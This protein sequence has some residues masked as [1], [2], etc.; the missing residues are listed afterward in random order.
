M[1][2]SKVIWTGLILCLFPC[3]VHSQGKFVQKFQYLAQTQIEDRR[4]PFTFYYI[5][6]SSINFKYKGATFYQFTF[7]EDSA[8]KNGFIGYDSKSGDLNFATDSSKTG[9]WNT[10][11]LF[12]LKTN[13][14]ITINH[15]LALSD[16]L[17]KTTDRN[18]VTFAV[19]LSGPIR[20]HD[21]HAIYLDRIEFEKGVLYPRSMTFFFPFDGGDI[22]LFPK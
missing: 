6:D 3:C 8:D 17:I 15:I 10:S 9:K 22:T 12:R 5:V 19:R 16:T 13:G 1:T 7:S 18:T 2:T 20:Q 14:S 4:V 11:K 21:S